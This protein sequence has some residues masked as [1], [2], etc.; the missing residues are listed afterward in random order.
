[1]VVISV[2][3][4]IFGIFGIIIGSISLKVDATN[5]SYYLFLFGG[6]LITFFGWLI[7]S[8]TESGEDLILWYQETRKK[9]RFKLFVKKYQSNDYYQ[10]YN[11]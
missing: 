6:V 4:F 9:I 1:M 10:Y 5:I 7:F 2:I 11:R 8:K 3:I